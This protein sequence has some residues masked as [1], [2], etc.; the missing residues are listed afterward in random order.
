MQNI[1]PFIWFDKNLKE[2]TDFYISAF[3]GS[4]I[5]SNGMLSDTPSGNV[6]TATM[7]IYGKQLSMMT[8]GPMYKLNPSISLFVTFD[9]EESI[10]NAWDTL[11]D[12]GKILMAYNTYPWASKY[13]W[14]QDKYGLTWQLSWSD[15]HGASN[16]ITPM[17]TFTQN[18]AGKVTEALALYT[19]LFPNSK[20]DMSVPYAE[21]EGDVAGYIKHARFSLNGEN[22]LAMESTAPHE[23]T[24]NEAF[25]FVINCKD[26]EEVDYYW[27]A[28]TTNGG[29]EGM[30]GWCKD[31]YGVSWQVTPHKLLEL[32]SGSDKE[33]SSYAAQQMMQMKK[34]I[35]VDLEKK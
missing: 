7:S 8:A 1:T 18:M 26:Q 4:T 30:C 17:L 24:F 16:N 33:K 32:I 5:T 21:G 2:I 10:K 31:K 28:L 20:I 29:A 12:G 15:N 9:N 35:I 14:L 25:S 6:E 27:N 23:F 11:V 3:P 22:F 34:I 19:S 13:G